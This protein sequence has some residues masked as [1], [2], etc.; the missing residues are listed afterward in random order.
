M[1][2]L[3]GSG[4]STQG[5]MLAQE[6]G[7]RWLSTGQ[8]LRDSAD[9]ATLEQ[10]NRGSLVSDAVIIPLVE[11]TLQQIF[12]QGEDVVMDGFPRTEAQAQWLVENVADKIE[13]ILR[14]IVPKSELIQRM[15]LR[16][17]ADDQ[18]IAAIEERFRQTEQNIYSVC[19]VFR[20]AGV[21]II[22]VDGRGS[23]EDVHERVKQV[24]TEEENE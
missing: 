9:V 20:K 14:I 23:V 2:G 24:I 3:A 6:T 18:D 4:K 21:K 8:M 7:R 5:Q 19:E 16:G 13:G 10:L 11:Q 17:R 12:E 1:M 22:D 15:K